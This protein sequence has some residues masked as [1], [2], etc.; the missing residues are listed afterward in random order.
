MAEPMN[1]YN[2]ASFMEDMGLNPENLHDL[3]GAEYSGG[4]KVLIRWTCAAWVD[5]QTYIA[6]IEKVIGGGAA[7]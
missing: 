4:D 7:E 6:A 5:H 1:E 3:E 2:P